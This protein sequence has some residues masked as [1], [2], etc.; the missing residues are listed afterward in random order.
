MKMARKELRENMNENT[1]VFQSIKAFYAM[2]VLIMAGRLAGLNER[3]RPNG[4]Q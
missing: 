4:K 1:N 2:N 3:K